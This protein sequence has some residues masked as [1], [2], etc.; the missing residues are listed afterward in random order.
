MI[1]LIVP[2][3]INIADSVASSTIPAPPPRLVVI[4][5]RIAFGRGVPPSVAAAV[6]SAV[7]AGAVGWWGS[8]LALARLADE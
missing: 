3:I 2:V 1:A 6:V 5:R 7:V 4:V 8:L